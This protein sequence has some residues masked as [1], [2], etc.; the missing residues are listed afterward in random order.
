MKKND[1]TSAE[2]QATPI[3]LI[4]IDW[5]FS[6]MNEVADVTRLAG[7]EYTEYWEEDKEG[8]ILALKGEN[9]GNNR[10]I[11]K[12]LAYIST[13]LSLK[14][15][16]SK[17][18]KGDIVYPCVGTIGN[19]FVVEE[20]NKYHINQNIAKISPKKDI[21]NSQYLAQYLM[22]DFC[23]SEILRFNATSSQPNIL[24]GSL[25]DYRLAIPSLAEQVIISEIL[26]TYDKTIYL[27][28]ILIGKKERR[29]KSLMQKLV[30]GNLRF[31][32]F[33]RT[34]WKDF[35]LSE[36]TSLITKGTTPSSM[37][38]GFSP[39][40]INF[41][42]IE[43]LSENGDFL[44]EK[45]MFINQKTHEQLKRS[46]LCENDIL[47][48]IAGAL[49]RVAIVSNS[50]LPA[51][52]NQALAIIR[53][54]ENSNLSLNYLYYY[55]KSEIIVKEIKAINVQAAQANLSL[56]NINNFIISAPSKDEQ[57]KIASVLSDTD[58]EILI[59]KTQL[60]KLK[61]QKKGLTQLLLTGKVRVKI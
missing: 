21:I 39:S 3:G 41:I 48:S 1:N 10:I 25:R 52:T 36:E 8:E 38:G 13:E 53:L 43:S 51:N 11:E 58:T 12:N 59:L 49:G 47:F 2:L 14:L 32:E 5:K 19:A 4:P 50:I 30:T 34:K 61:L 15:S 33:G 44:K 6:L 42:K 31:S 24:V 45:I 60:D 20:D 22:S 23:K 7:Y 27:T 28:S 26:N 16:R 46:Q 18:F 40:G 55:L 54:K 56:A 9:I 37:G 17:L 57:Q 29:K 35:E